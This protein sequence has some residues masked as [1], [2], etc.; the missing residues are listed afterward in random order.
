V[1]GR[2]R[3]RGS[4]SFWLACLPV[5]SLLSGCL[6]VSSLVPRAPGRPPG[7]RSSSASSRRRRPLITMHIASSHHRPPA[8]A[9]PQEKAKARRTGNQEAG[10]RQEGASCFVFLR[11]VCGCACS[12]WL[13]SAV[14]RPHHS[15]HCL[16]TSSSRPAGRTWLANYSLLCASPHNKYKCESCESQL[17]AG[18]AHRLCNYSSSLHERPLHT[19]SHSKATFRSL[20][21]LVL[22]CF[23][24]PKSATN[25]LRAKN[26]L[27]VLD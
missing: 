2:Q 10:G 13:R 18:S 19:Y 21:G 9:R 26:L 8:P 6:T 16:L 1:E 27:S 15:Q 23:T 4:K 24:L 3:G 5:R 25:L 12:G 17:H 20:D 7:R 14:F 22:H 11:R